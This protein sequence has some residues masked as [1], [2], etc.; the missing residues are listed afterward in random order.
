MHRKALLQHIFQFQG[1][2][3]MPIGNLNNSSSP[4]NQNSLV[5]Q[6]KLKKIIRH[7][8]SRIRLTNIK[9]HYLFKILY[10]CGISFFKILNRFISSLNK[11]KNVVNDLIVEP[12]FYFLIR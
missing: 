3:G 4:H 6:K 2:N 9:R 10:S 12:A 1:G 11:L 7:F 5:I 8:V